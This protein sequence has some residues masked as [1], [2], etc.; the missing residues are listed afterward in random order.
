MT[1]RN[2]N[3]VPDVADFETACAIMTEMADIAG[4][5]PWSMPRTLA[6][7]VA[8]I[9]SNERLIPHAPDGLSHAVGTPPSRAQI[10]S[11]EYLR[12]P[13]SRFPAAFKRWVDDATLHT[14]TVMR[15]IRGAWHVVYRSYYGLTDAYGQPYV[16]IYPDTVSLLADGWIVD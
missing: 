6:Q 4:R 8:T 12:N 10:E 7:W 16:A 5:A 15:D 13:S 2:E 3:I 1:T 11:L 14:G 9:R